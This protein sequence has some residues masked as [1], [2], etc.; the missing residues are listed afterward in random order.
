[1]SN[2]IKKIHIFFIGLSFLIGIVFVFSA[3]S[4]TSPVQYF[5]Y[6]IHSQLPVPRYVAQLLARFFIG[7]EAA[8]G[9]LLA[10]NI[11]GYK[12][13]VLKVSLLLLSIFSIHLVYLLIAVGNDVNC[14]CMGNIVPMSPALSL[15]KNLALLAGLIILHKWGNNEENKVLNIATFPVSILIVLLPFFIFPV[16][17]QNFLPLSKLYT[18]TESA[19][20]VTELREGKHILCF[21]S[22]SCSHCR[23]AASVLAVMKKSNPSLPIY[24]ALSAGDSLSRKERFEDFMKE[25][26]AISIPYHF[27]SPKD[28][29]DM[30]IASGSDGVPVMLW[31][32]DSTIIRQVDITELNQRE[33][34]LWI[35][36]NK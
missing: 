31:L 11:F 5:E 22:L 6:T 16:A 33:I 9:L 21:M 7:L 32:E 1:M 28:F 30:I 14:G 12:K 2:N 13:W 15:A 20:P 3:W 29:T 18:S 10:I 24:F 36:K 8:L 27:L 26:K 34:E 19:H 25:T 35:N 17:K 23:N 4:K